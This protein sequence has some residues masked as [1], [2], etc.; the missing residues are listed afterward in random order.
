[1]FKIYDN[2]IVMCKSISVLIANTRKSIKQA[3]CSQSLRFLW[4]RKP[5][6]QR[7]TDK[8][9]AFVGLPITIAFDVRDSTF[10]CK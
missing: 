4:Q 3:L 1:M 7:K 10:F 9:T 5:I 6:P 2:L 8:E